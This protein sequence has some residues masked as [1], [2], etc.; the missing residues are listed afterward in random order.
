VDKIVDMQ[1]AA[2]QIFNLGKPLESGMPWVPVIDTT[3]NDVIGQPLELLASGQFEKMPIMMGT[4]WQDCLPFIYMGF[5]NYMS[6]LE[7]SAVVLAV[8]PQIFQQVMA[9]YPPTPIFGDKRPWL[10]VLGTD[11][12]FDCP[13]RYALENIQQHLSSSGFN[14]YLYNFNQSLSYDGW[15]PNYTF[16]IGKVCHGIELPYLFDSARGAGFTTTNDEEILSHYMGAYWTNFARSGDPNKGAQPGQKVFWPP[17]NSAS[18]P[19]MELSAP[20]A[21]IVTQYRSDKCNWWDSKGYNWGWGNNGDDLASNN[22]LM[23]QMRE[24]WKKN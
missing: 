2:D 6:D 23:I 18:R 3:D 16:C 1:K 15:G 24:A 11:Y 19:Q 22:K 9:Q 7:Y 10:A 20:S 12:V 14:A 5:K 8:F 17:Y 4:V 13:T 21:S